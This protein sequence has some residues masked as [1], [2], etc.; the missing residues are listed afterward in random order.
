M[1]DRFNAQNAADVN[2]AETVVDSMRF[3]RFRVEARLGVDSM[4]MVERAFDTV[5]RVTVALKTIRPELA[6]GLRCVR[7]TARA[8]PPRGHRRGAIA[9][10]AVPRAGL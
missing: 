8:V 6:L 7:R 5:L 1:A 2:N 3:G 10:C 4:G 9:R